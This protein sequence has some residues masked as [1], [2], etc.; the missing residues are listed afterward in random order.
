[1]LNIDVTVRVFLEESQPEP[2]Y[3]RCQY[4]DAH[5]PIIPLLR[6]NLPRFKDSFISRMPRLL[7]RLY[8]SMCSGSRN[9]SIV[10]RRLPIH[11]YKLIL[12]QPPPPIKIKFPSSFPTN[13]FSN[14]RFDRKVTGVY[15]SRCELVGN[16]SLRSI[17][18]D[19]PYTLRWTECFSCWEL[20]R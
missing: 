7:C 14:R 18:L 20:A 6:Y 4:L 11:F 1:M 17:I 2:F 10:S 12:S 15:E 16:A 3:R 19:R 5:S 8:S 13:N 9:T